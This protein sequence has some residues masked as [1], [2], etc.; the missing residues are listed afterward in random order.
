MSPRPST[1]RS[2][3]ARVRRARSA[4]VSRK[5]STSLGRA[6]SAP[7]ALRG[8]TNAELISLAR[9]LNQAFNHFTKKHKA[10]MERLHA[11]AV[12]MGALRNSNYREA[13]EAALA[14]HKRH[15]ASLHGKR[16]RLVLE[17]IGN[18]R[19]TP[20]RRRLYTEGVRRGTHGTSQ[21]NWQNWT[22]KLWY[23][24]RKF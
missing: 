13:R 9:E 10:Q 19:S 24:T 4:S 8:A 17:L 22:N 3:S 23:N 12:A 2:R 20:T 14:I 18:S 6:R 16:N 1:T 21:N 15:M 7:A 11:N 5:R